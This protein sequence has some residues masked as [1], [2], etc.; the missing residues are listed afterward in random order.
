MKKVVAGIVVVMLLAVVGI[1]A[2]IKVYP[3]IRLMSETKGV[4][5]ENG[6]YQMDCYLSS[7]ETAGMEF[8]FQ[9]HGEKAGGMISGTIGDEVEESFVIDR[10]NTQAYFNI[11]KLGVMLVESITGDESDRNWLTD[12]IVEYVNEYEDSNDAL[13]IT[14]DQVKMILGNENIELPGFLMPMGLLMGNVEDADFKIRKA[15]MQENFE[16]DGKYLFQIE[17][18]YE[19]SDFYLAVDKKGEKGNAFQVICVNGESIVKADIFFTEDETVNVQTP[20]SIVSDKVIEFIA[21]MYQ[22]G[23]S[24]S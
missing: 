16:I 13:Y 3:Y 8:L 22:L 5:K 9:V 17:E 15:K 23:A 7:Q 18:T 19:D 2:G 4:L 1:V 6:S 10:N 21:A 20:E 14:M 24:A 12:T 11:V